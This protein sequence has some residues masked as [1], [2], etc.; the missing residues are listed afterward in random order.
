MAND[1]SS[2][3]AITELNDP[4]VVKNV[5]RYLDFKAQIKAYQKST[6]Q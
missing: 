2:S 1:L 6:L 3:D 5:E 4:I